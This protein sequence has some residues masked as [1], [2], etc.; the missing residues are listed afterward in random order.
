MKSDLLESVLS[1]IRRLSMLK[2]GDKVLVAVSGGPDSVALLHALWSLR[3]ELGITLHAA[4]LNHSFRG[5]ES[6]QDAEYVARLAGNLRV[7]CTVE[8]IDVPEIQRT[9]RL[10]PEEAARLVRYEFLARVADEVGANR[11]AVGHT[12][13]DQVE[14]VLLNILRGAGIDGLSGMPPVRGRIIRPLIETRRSVVEEYVER[15]NLRPRIDATNLI[16]TYARNR[17]RLELL[18]LL[19]REYN[20]EVDAAILRLSELATEDSA[21]LNMEAEETLARLKT[22][23]NEQSLSLDVPGLLECRPAIRRRVIRSAVSE[24]RGGLADI[25][26][27][28]VEDLLRLLDGGKDFRYELPGGI[29]VERAREILTFSSS[30]IA[31]LPIIYCYELRVPGK[32]EVP[33]IGVIIEV[34][35]S[36]TLIEPMR[37]PDSLEVV[38]DR[39]SIVGKL[40]V[41]SWEPGDRIRPLG[42]GGSKK[43]QDIFV[44]RK[45][46]RA[47]RHRVP[48]IADDEKIV[49]IAGL[50]MS[51]SVKVTGRTREF[52]V[53][54]SMPA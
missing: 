35:L 53:L 29:Y 49:W 9:L 7:P 34:D 20:P 48:I 40:R 17:I 52:L 54:R 33:E 10:S 45:I 1:T 32:T 25:G 42:L 23:Q 22:S 47:A 14:T 24:L 51:E 5:K 37:P 16:A 43:I 11:I 31:E 44:D 28:H 41:R 8:K 30:K 50:A 3:D 12:A 6:D 13:D 36:Q 27:V 15:H 18:P 26:F 39:D 4:H 46:P 21:Y 38:L 2:P 19:R